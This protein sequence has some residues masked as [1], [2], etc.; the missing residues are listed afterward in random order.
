MTAHADFDALRIPL[1]G[2]A[3]VDASAGTGKTYAITTLVVRLLVEN[4][5]TVDRILIVTFTEAATGELRG[6]VRERIRSAVEAFAPAPTNSGDDALDAYVLEYERR[7]GT[8]ARRRAELRLRDALASI[9][10][11]AIS[12]IH[13]FCYQVLRRAA[14]VTG[15][16]FDCEIA[17]TDRAELRQLVDDLWS[18]TLFQASPGEAER[19]FGKSDPRRALQRLIDQLNKNP[20]LL[21]VPD[22][23]TRP[24]HMAP[25]REAYYATRALWNGPRILELLQRDA[26]PREN[27]KRQRLWQ[28]VSDYLAPSEPQSESFTKKTPQKNLRAVVKQI[29]PQAHDDS[30][31]ESWCS[32]ASELARRLEGYSQETSDLLLAIKHEA[33]K[34]ALAPRPATSA[35]TLTFDALLQT[36]RDA[37]FG[38]GG[39]A[40]TAVL[41]AEFGAALVDEFQDT[42]PT[43]FSI[44]QR[45]FGSGRMP[46]FLIG[47][48]KQAIYAFRGADVFAYLKAARDLEGERYTM[49]TNW[50]S[51]PALVNAV[52]IV[53]SHREEARAPFVIPQI[54][55]PKVQPRPGAL[56]QFVGGESVGNAAF[57][58]LL[59]RSQG[60][61]PRELK[62]PALSARATEATAADIARLLSSPVRIAGQIVRPE[63]IAVLARTN[64]QC[65]DLQLQLRKRGVPSVVMGDKNV[66]E[67]HE[68][69][70]LLTLFDALLEPTHGTYLRRALATDLLGFDASQL[71]ALEE[72][73]DDWEVW[74]DRFRR[75]HVLWASRGFVQ[76]FRQLMAETQIAPRLLR[77]LDGERRMTNLLHL[78]EL[79]FVA[80]RSAHLGPAAL[81]FWLRDER[82]NIREGR[83]TSSEQ[84]ELRLESDDAAVK[85]TTIHK[86]KGLEFDVV[87]CPY[88]W[89]GKLLHR[90]ETS[91]PKFHDEEGRACIDLG[92]DQ[93]E[94]H[95]NLAKHEAL[96]ENLRLLYV[97]LTRAR[98]RCT[99]CWAP[100]ES[101]DTSALAYLLG[102]DQPLDSGAED[103]HVACWNALAATSRGAI[104]TRDALSEDDDARYAFEDQD[105]T[106]GPARTLR[107][108]L[109]AWWRTTSFTAL[110]RHDEAHWGSLRRRPE[111]DLDNTSNAAAADPEK[112]SAVAPA[113]TL[114]AFPRGAAA[115]TC[116]HDLL[117]Q[118]DFDEATQWETQVALQLQRHGFQEDLAPA[119]LLS[120]QE[121]TGTPLRDDGTLRLCDLPRANTVR[122]LEF[123][124]PLADSGGLSAL[125][126]SRALG[127]APSAGLPDDYPQAVAQ[128]GFEQLHGF[129]KG[130]V[131]LIFEHDERFYVV[132]YK[133]NHLGELRSQYD[134]SAMQQVMCESHYHLQYHLYVLA[135]HRHLQ[136]RIKD[137]DYERHFGGVY[138]L[139]LKGMH[140]ED[141][142]SGIFF[143]RPPARRMTALDALFLAV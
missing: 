74:V 31:V 11:A 95:K 85:L 58:V 72:H 126:L 32:A 2:C 122:E 108:A 143:D 100:A 50:R 91:Q 23:P 40:L 92:S 10:Q 136:R 64:Q 77:L 44:F 9:D 80:A 133:T 105:K 49:T 88:L 51:D 132:D 107:E 138:Y 5:L 82:F 19:L 48:P 25:I 8:E 98:H 130:Y 46:F 21:L 128:L 20:E 137:Y 53:F 119:L 96:A 63:Q 4:E 24:E 27:D 30:A 71:A 79:L 35:Q 123:H 89:D 78:T 102:L 115:G 127:S 103:C 43:Q 142:Q 69:D 124:L 55:Y 56:D 113:I 99:V 13:G 104:G 66:F 84:I 37:L 141:E 16:P 81:A 52:N 15:I 6:R 86:S 17:Q 59:L 61:L 111:R 65:F 36:L 140:P 93:M 54:Q 125:E 34:R 114:Q 57:D 67:T 14:F 3:L 87:Y 83:D 41:Q 121:I 38:P 110:T 109:S 73:S 45:A 94:P 39:D 62:T 18:E 70:E 7:F 1:K 112:D 117:E 129:L 131:D 118:I 120:L 97:A 76:M 106:T 29:S 22:A 68:A 101:A 60:R 116:Y 28:S 90:G 33:A 42:D 139:F 12:T 47:D 135:L 26:R 134:P 75:L